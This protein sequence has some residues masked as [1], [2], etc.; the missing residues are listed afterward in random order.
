MAPLDSAA[1]PMALPDISSGQPAGEN[2]EFDPAFAELERLAQGKPEQQ[3]GST[4]VPAEEPDWKEVAASARAL[5]QRTHDLRVLGRL[6]VARLQREGM[7]GYAETMAMIR[8]VL[9]TRWTA[10]H[11][12]LDPEDDNDPTLRA[13]ALLALA[14]PMRV[15][16]FLRYMPLARSVRAG[17][18][19]WRDIS[20]STSM[21]EVEDGTPKMTASVIAAAFRDTDGAALAGLRAAVASAIASAAAIPA[22]FDEHAGHGAGPDFTD[23]TKLLREIARMTDTYAQAAPEAA[24]PED[25]GP[26]AGAVRPE[27]TEVGPPPAAARAAP[28]MSIA[29][30]GPPTNR[31]DALRL[32]DLVIEFYERSEPSSPL[33]LLIARARRLADK[34]FLDILRD[35]APDGVSQAERIAGT[36][37]AE[38]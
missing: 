28:A 1:D 3:Y 30:M 19:S 32:L 31:A 10:V 22:A 2:L 5:M 26:D 38:Y 18:V 16:R 23:L 36:P 15:M 14:E 7:G 12:Q 17:A 25:A 4:I 35:M 27:A 8:Q 21:I 6:A 34:G 29:T 9:E 24:A 13:N 11:P 20:F 33:P 37:S